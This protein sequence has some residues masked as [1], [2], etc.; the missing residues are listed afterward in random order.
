MGCFQG[1]CFFPREAT[2]LASIVEDVADDIL[3]PK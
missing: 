2:K 1:V 3:I